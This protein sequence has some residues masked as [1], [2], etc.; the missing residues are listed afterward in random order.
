MTFESI[1]HANF[2]VTI[3][4]TNEYTENEINRVRLVADELLQ[5]T[6]NQCQERARAPFPEVVL[7]HL[8]HEGIALRVSTTQAIDADRFN[9]HHDFFA[10]RL[11]ELQRVSNTFQ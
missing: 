5:A 10:H 2:S 6:I 9:A 8:V 11:A 1:S 4:V 7:A 3:R